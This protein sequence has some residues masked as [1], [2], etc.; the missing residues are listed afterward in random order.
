MQWQQQQQHP[1][2][3]PRARLAVAGGPA[4][5]CAEQQ[6]NNWYTMAALLALNA[7]TR[8]AVIVLPGRCTHVRATPQPITSS[9]ADS[10]PSCL[11]QVQ[12]CAQDVGHHHQQVT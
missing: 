12:G 9:I 4:A 7:W 3:Q 11:L 8:C 5:L 10:A 6:L 2:Q 1:C